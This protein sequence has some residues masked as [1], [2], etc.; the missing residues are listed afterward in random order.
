MTIRAYIA[1]APGLA[2][3]LIEASCEKFEI[4]C[5]TSSAPD[6]IFDEIKN[7]RPDILFIDES[8]DL[9]KNFSAVSDL[10]DI[11]ELEGLLIIYTSPDVN[12]AGAADKMGADAFL[13]IPFSA[14]KFHSFVRGL[15]EH[16]KSIIIID[17]DQEK[18]KDLFQTLT[19]A[20][21]NVLFANSG[22]KGIALVHK[23]FPDLIVASMNLNDMTGLDFS[24]KIKNARLASNIPVIILSDGSRADMIDDCF[25][26]GIH[27][28]LLAP[29][30]G[31]ENI[32]KIAQIVS[33]PK[34]GRRDSVLVIDDSPMV[35]N[36]ISKMCRNL[37]YTVFTAENG[38]EALEVAVKNPPDIITCDYDMPVM[39]GW[40]FCVEAKKN[41]DIKSIPIIMVTARGT[42]V[43]MK[44]GRVL[45]VDEYLTKP[46]KE[47]EL[48]AVITKVLK[49]AKKR[50]EREELKKYVASDV[51]SSVSEMIDGVRDREPE[52]KFITILFADICSF[53]SI[54]ERLNPRAVV[55]L[56]NSA[57]DVMIHVLQR[58]N[59]I[60][61][62]F[63]GDAI[64]AR[65]DSG[66]AR[67]DALNAVRSAWE[68]LKAM[69]D[70]NLYSMESVELRIGVNS[71]NVILGNIGSE[72]YR[73][74]YTMIG[75]NVNITQRLEGIAPRMGCMISQDTYT[76]VKDMVT[77]GE[78]V[79]LSL[80]GKSSAITAYRLEGVKEKV[81][82]PD[83]AR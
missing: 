28:V 48:L 46:F 12:S 34:K 69:E 65:F 35:R 75:D 72:S 30:D 71:G 5:V 13:P 81:S 53:T 68:I 20:G 14:A 79:E 51:L 38:L 21:Y 78:S 6:K 66:D 45:G 76:L 59:A 61:D 57:F 25:N 11:P 23:T 80:K 52:E 42:D 16:P 37:G 39:N 27:T 63:I 58:N 67:E 82:A 7:I 9:A 41:P 54:C 55:Q 64:A 18:I 60:I 62:K 47:E 31:R 44:K 8:I 70:F 40:E 43:D 26:A 1:S 50:K 77:T 36:L 15:L 49:Q 32:D 73:L 17:S 10:R 56:L 33:P 2:S 4:E 29:F 22:D 24:M 3:R 19:S 83:E 74:D